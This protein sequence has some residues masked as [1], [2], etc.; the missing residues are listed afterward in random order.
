MKPYWLKALDNMTYFIL[1]GIDFQQL[2]ADDV[3]DLT[4]RCSASTDVTLDFSNFNAILAPDSY[5][6]QSGASEMCEW[7]VSGPTGSQFA[8]IINDFLLAADAGDVFE[9]RY[10]DGRDS[11]G[12][13]RYSTSVV[14][15]PLTV[16]PTVYSIMGTPIVIDTNQFTVA[17]SASNVMAANKGPL[18]EVHILDAGKKA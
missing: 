11:V 15:I 18:F 2:T 12:F 13:L 8:L 6:T 9:I 4:H 10:A 14:D 5:F 16:D 17:Y 3:D 7:V 1:T